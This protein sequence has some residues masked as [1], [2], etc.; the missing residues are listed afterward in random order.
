MAKERNNS[1]AFSKNT[2]S[3]GQDWWSAS[4]SFSVML[5]IITNML[6]PMNEEPSESASSLASPDL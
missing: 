1:V 4:L 6:D 5:T 2:A 3:L